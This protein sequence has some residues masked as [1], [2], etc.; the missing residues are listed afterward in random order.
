MPRRC[1]ICTH[2]DRDTIDAQLAAGTPYRHIAARFDVSTGALHRHGEQH[3]PEHL[4]KAANAEEAASAERLLNQVLE[5]NRR[6]QG[7]L[8][9]AEAEGEHRTALA[10]IREARGCLELLARLLG[11]LQTDTSITVN[12][13]ESPEWLELRQVILV[14]LQPHPDAREAVLRALPN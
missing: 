3:L 6:A 8:D 1:T 14:A 7:I 11:E 9:K 12:I 13:V 5:L 10:A 2:D 4:A